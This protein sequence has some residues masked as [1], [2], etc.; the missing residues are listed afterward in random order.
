ASAVMR[1]VNGLKKPGFPRP[2]AKAAPPKERSSTPAITDSRR[3][4]V[5]RS[6]TLLTTGWGA[7][8]VSIV[9]IFRTPVLQ[10]RDFRYLLIARLFVT[11]ALQIQAVVVGWQIYQLSHDPLLLGLIG[12][13]EALPAIVCSFFSGHIVDRHRPAIVYAIAVWSIFFNGCL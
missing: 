1:T 13:A 12:L 5:K 6:G 8:E 2:R 9:N 10:I 7:G 3:F 4:H 11:M